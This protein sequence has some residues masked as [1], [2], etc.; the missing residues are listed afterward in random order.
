MS[1]TTAEKLQIDLPI[2]VE[3]KYDRLRLLSIC[4]ADIFTT[5]GF[6]IFNSRERLALFRRLAERGGILLLTDSDGAGGVI[7]RYIGSAIPPDRIY[8]LRI[9]KIEGKERRKASRS[10]EGL[11]GVEG[12]TPE[13]LRS[14]LLP[15]AGGRRPVRAGIAKADLFACGLSGGSDSSAH[16]DRLAEA[17]GLPAGMTANALLSALNIVT[18]KESFFRMAKTLFTEDPQS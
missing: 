15:Y 9:P 14:L 16:R 7:R 11:L 8:H 5:G 13:L 18:D 10:A 4:D 2:I 17:F 12:M 1:E 6:A 3:G